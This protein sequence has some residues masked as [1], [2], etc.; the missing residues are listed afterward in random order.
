MPIGFFGQHSVCTCV[1]SLGL[2]PHSPSLLKVSADLSLD[3][4][5]H[6]SKSVT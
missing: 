5:M 4:W 2:L 6:A 3:V 1:L